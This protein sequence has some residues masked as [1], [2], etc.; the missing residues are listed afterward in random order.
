[1]SLLLEDATPYPHAGALK[2]RDVTTDPTTG[3][4]LLRIVF[5]NPDAVLLPGMF[6]RAL[7]E[8]GVNE[9]A[10]LIPQQGVAR[11]PK[12]EPIALVVAA[13]DTVRQ[14][15]LT[16]DRAIGSHWLVATG[17]QA[18]DRVIVEGSLRV[19]PGM[20]VNAVPFDDGRANGAGPDK[21]PSPGQAPAN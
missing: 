9:R 5:P 19:R 10:L 6:V 2:F 11:T 1:M 20:A 13:G 8:E 18:G 15:L 3:S 12:G 16:L 14:K 17:I 7:V 21:K 4:V